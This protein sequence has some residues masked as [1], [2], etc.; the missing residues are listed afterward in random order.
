M[1]TPVAWSNAFDLNLRLADAQTQVRFVQLRNG[2]FWMVWTDLKDTGVGSSSGTDL[3]GQR[4]N[5]FGEPQGGEVRLNSN[6]FA[7]DERNADLAADVGSDEFFIAFE[8]RNATGDVDI[9]LER[10]NG[11]GSGIDFASIANDPTNDATGIDFRNPRVAVASATSGLVVFER[12]DDAG[13]TDIVGQ[14]FDSSTGDLVGANFTIADD[15]LD[16]TDPQIVATSDGRYA[17]VWTDENPASPGTTDIQGAY[18]TQ[19]GATTL[20]TV[21][22][23]S[24]AER[25]PSVAALSG[26]RIVATW[27]LSDAIVGAVFEPN[28]TVF[29][30]AFVIANTAGLAGD[31]RVVAI[32]G[33][34]FAVAWENI[35]TDQIQVAAFDVGAGSVAQSGSTAVAANVESVSDLSLIGLADG[36]VLIGYDSPLANAQIFDPRAGINATAVYAPIDQQIG[37]PGND[38]FTAAANTDIVHGWDGDDDITDGSGT[39]ANYFGGNGND[40]IRASFVDSGESADGGAG[41]DRLVYTALAGPTT[42]NLL[43][44]TATTGVVTQSVINFESFTT[45]VAQDVTVIGSNSNGTL[46]TGPGNDT[47]SLGSVGGIM[48]GSSGNDTYLVD[49]LLDNVAEAAGQGTDEVVTSL[50]GYT[51]TANVEELTYTGS[52]A[53][54]LRGNAGNNTVTG[55]Q[56]GDLFLLQ[57]GGADTAIGGDGDDTF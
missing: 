8:D 14:R 18:I 52:L 2:D 13:N 21:S 38:V 28:G 24:G 4:Y 7:T 30:P 56:L 19:A 36:R 44:G 40:T 10:K 17:V 35:T 11:D 15:A 1:P 39:E 47:L 5:A 12:T 41:I 6:F 3:V 23:L 16:L 46:I 50:T 34:A 9:I 51:L 32:G 29:V 54:N 31:S 25:D 57:D 26:G 55:G 42:V 48:A 53:A 49:N 22:T 45:D 33:A 20:F 27:T 43:A 37:T